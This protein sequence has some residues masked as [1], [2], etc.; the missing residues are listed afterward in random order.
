MADLI[1]VIS[2]TAIAKAGLDLLNTGLET[3]N[4]KRRKSRLEQ[5]SEW[6]NDSYKAMKDNSF[7][8]SKM[9]KWMAGSIAAG[10]GLYAVRS[11]LKSV[12]R[13][14]ISE[15]TVLITG[16]SRGLG[17]VLARHLAE[18][19]A[20]VIICARHKKA[21]ERAT[22]DI[23]ERGD[24]VTAIQCDITDKQQVQN[25]IKEI[26]QKVGTVNVLI[27]NASRIQVGPMENMTEEDYKEAMNVH[28]WGPLY[29][30]NQIIPTMIKHK[31]GRIVNIVS[32]NGKISIPHLLP[33][34][35]SKYA[36]AGLSEGMTTELS[37]HNVKVT[38]IYPGLMRTGSPRNAEVKGQFEKEFAWFKITDSLPLLTI[39]VDRA[40]RKIISA[41]KDGRKTLTLTPPAKI[42][43]VAH[44]LAPSFTISTL[45]VLNSLLPESADGRTDSK[46]GYES[47]SRLS[48]SFLTRMTKNAENYTLE[49][50]PR[51][52]GS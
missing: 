19:G 28:F 29:V 48:E 38:T 8:Q 3:L 47:S 4:I 6:G 5:M 24:N 12:T 22:E 34:N 32:L 41:M 37:K 2:K 23:S 35:S 51:A 52:N 9:G 50:I 43:E 39:N 16:G 49:R 13:Y 26:E 46:K 36:L 25:M 15:K 1:N 21:L 7:L 11:V 14:D 30:M 17:L 44:G 31:E 45:N 42:A 10:V 18:E 40:A 27:N 20:K 33:Y